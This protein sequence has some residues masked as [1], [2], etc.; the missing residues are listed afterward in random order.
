L[1]WQGLDQ[2]Q[3]WALAIGGSIAA[4]GIIWLCTKLFG[5]RKE[6]DAGVTVRQNASPTVTQ[7][8]QP[9]INIHSPVAS[10][11]EPVRREQQKRAGGSPA[12]SLP[13]FEYRGYREKAVFIS[14]DARSGIHDPRDSNEIE[15]A[16]EALVL[17]FENEPQG[18][19]SA[20]AMDVVAKIS[21]QSSSGFREEIDYGIWLNS[22]CECTD[23]DAGDTRELL[24][25]AVMD[26][27]LFGFD[28]RR[29]TNHDYDPEWSWLADRHVNDLES[30]EI[31][32][33]DR[34]TAATRKFT[35]EIHYDGE[36]FAVSNTDLSLPLVGVPLRRPMPPIGP[37]A[38]DLL[39]EASKDRQG[40]VMSLQTM[41]GSSVQTNGKNF[42]ERG[43]PRSEARWRGAVAELSNARLLED[44]AG[45]GEVFFV[46]EEGYR[47]AGLLKQ[48]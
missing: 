8:F 33:V 44:R 32:L 47:T 1:T 26:G 9:T 20:R 40:V 4:A 38:R 18:T 37:A 39:I 17:R 15:R 5:K 43:D 10:S 2:W 30:V 27:K 16:I 46:T 12:K 24:L 6:A 14:P 11:T 13:H 25:I 3:Q 21:F 23:M 19:I 35:L 34:H 29:E 7:T 36:H 42:A 45:E 48:R 31:R 22:P 41:D 28:D